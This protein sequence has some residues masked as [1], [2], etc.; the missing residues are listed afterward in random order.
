[1]E[2]IFIDYVGPLPRTKG[3]HRYILV[4]VD[5]FTRF[6]WLTPT[7]GVTAGGTINQLSKI[8]AWFGPPK[9]LVSD[10]APAFVSREF[11]GF[12]FRQGIS[13]VTTAPYYPQ[14]S[15]AERFNRNLKAALIA[16]HSESQ[17]KWDRSLPWLNLA[18]NT[19]KH[20]THQNTP[21]S[22]LFAYAVNSPLSNLWS[23]GDLLPEKITSESIRENWTRA[24]T[25]IQRAHAREAE[26]YNRGRRP[27]RFKKGDLVYVK[28]FGGMG[29]KLAPRFIGPWE[30]LGAPTPVT[31]R[32]RNKKTNRLQRVH[33]SQVKACG[34]I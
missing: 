22:L 6:V 23:F 18:F 10:N 11:K 7:N 30:V 5:S 17:H 33:V 34:P 29:S 16:Y 3:G 21:A 4:V 31:L 1:M 15:F 28:N 19:A 13:H 32:V 2:R 8:F 9:V 20:E 27:A 24:R 25:N 12:C 14:P 26:R